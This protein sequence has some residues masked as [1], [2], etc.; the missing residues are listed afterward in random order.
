MS[1]ARRLGLTAGAVTL[2]GA[3][4]L[5]TLFTTL[6]WFAYSM[7]AVGLTIGA[8]MLSRRPG[9]PS[10]LPTVSGAVGLVVALTWLFPSGRELL[11]IIPTGHTF[12]HF[13]ELLAQSGQVIQENAIPVRGLPELLFLVALGVG[14]VALLVDLLAVGLRRPAMA[15]LPLLAIYAVPVAIHRDSAPVLP[16][17]IGAAGFLWLIAAD[18]GARIRQFGRRFSGDGRSVDSWEPS[19]L[20]AAGRRLSFVGVLLAVIIPILLPAMSADLFTSTGSS[21]SGHGGA[22]GNGGRGNGR[23]TTVDLFADLAGRLNQ[24]EQQELA[25]YRTTE[26]DPWYLRFA[27]ADIATDNGFTVQPWT[28]RPI[29]EAFADPTYRAE[30]PSGPRYRAE[31]EINNR[32]QQTMLPVFDHLSAIDGVGDPWNYA[33]DQG[34]IFSAR[35]SSAG[36][37]YQFEY[38]RPK[39][40]SAAL[41]L[42]PQ[43]SLDAPLAADTVVAHLPGVTS[44]VLQLTKGKRTDYD[45]VK[46]LYDHFSAKNGFQYSLTTRPGNTGAAVTD[47]LTNKSGYCEQYAVTLAWLVREAGIPARVAFGFGRGSSTT[48]DGTEYLLTN[49][50]LH[51]WTEVYFE[52]FGWVPFD[53]TP[54]V[55]G[56]TTEWSP[57]LNPISTT[58]PAVDGGGQSAPGRPQATTAPSR[59]PRPDAGGGPGGVPLPATDKTAAW[60]LVGLIGAVLLLLIAPLHRHRLRRRR[61]H[62]LPP[63]HPTP[64]P[65]PEPVGDQPWRRYAHDSWAELIDTMIDYGIDVRST[66]TPRGTIFRLTRDLQLAGPAAAAA[67][68]LGQAEERARYARQA[69]DTATDAAVELVRAQIAAGS[70]RWRRLLVVVAPLSVLRRWAAVG[71]ARLGQLTQWCSAM[72]E[73][74]RRWRRRIT[75]GRAS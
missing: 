75:P 1:S 43:H 18:Q 9:L 2:L 74:P 29:P 71:S 14:T 49:R 39:I 45:R 54:Q 52:G 38:V 35:Q 11:R 58:N 20:A 31:V 6:S 12:Q 32:F 10:W 69:D 70:G 28:G 40:T 21:T 15:G 56:V 68:L 22:G 3:V 4:P 51:A 24:P 50:N 53:A 62:R 47:F 17:I 41:R 19:P 57:P 65:Q 72:A 23:T 46:A 63:G 25:R 27:V 36:A 67:K 16:F 13:G 37:R 73:Y 66:E 26:K 7:V 42:A 33:A 60:W 61:Q 44:L 59:R 8:A 34:T 5:A 55:G 48:K 30:L 64:G